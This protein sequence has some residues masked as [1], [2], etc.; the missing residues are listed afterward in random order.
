MAAGGISVLLLAAIAVGAAIG[1]VL[2]QQGAWL[3]EQV[4]LTLLLLIGL[5]FFGVRFDALARALGHLRFIA[6][7]LLANFVL[8]PCIGWGIARAILPD[9]PL[10]MVGLVIYF[11]S[12]CTDWFLGFTRLARGNVALGTA[13]IPINM[14]LQLLLYPLYLHLVTRHVV[15]VDGGVIGTTLLQWFLLPLAVAMTAHQALRALLGPACF[16]RLLARV[17]AVT[18]WVIALLVAEIFAANVETLLAQRGMLGWLLLAVLLFFIATFMLGELLGR[19]AHL[20][21]P[22]H[23]LLTMTMAAR[24]APLMLAVTMA[25]LPGQPLVHAAIIIGMLLEFPHLTLLRHLLLRDP[26]RCLRPAAAG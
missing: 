18:P 25:A 21:H 15:P 23:A 12:P 17:D 13:L 7:A 9:H 10:F 3:G 22:E 5:L 24:N 20:E 8:V 1:H 2:P 16:E 11:M 14:V 26:A 6:L 19:L 4:D